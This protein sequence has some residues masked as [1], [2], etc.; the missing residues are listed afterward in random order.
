MIT[1]DHIIAYAINPRY[2]G[3]NLSSKD[4][5]IVHSFFQQN[6]QYNDAYRMFK[7]KTGNQLSTNFIT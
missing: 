5:A 4:L 6:Q 2:R 3:K 1:D 7:S